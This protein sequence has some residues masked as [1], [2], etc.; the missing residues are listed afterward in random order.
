MLSSTYVEVLFIPSVTAHFSLHRNTSS[1]I[2]LVTGQSLASWVSLA[3]GCESD[4]DA[5][6]LRTVNARLHWVTWKLLEVADRLDWME[7]IE[8]D[9]L[10]TEMVGNELRME[11]WEFKAVHRNPAGV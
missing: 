9:G 11:V 6:E 3:Q 2:L 7:V 5:S 10:D 8:V 1:S 4:R